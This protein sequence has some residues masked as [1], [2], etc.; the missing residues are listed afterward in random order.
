MSAITFRTGASWL[1]CGHIVVVECFFRK[2]QRE[3]SVWVEFPILKQSKLDCHSGQF[4]DCILL[5][6]S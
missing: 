6:N 5:W 2:K 3:R 1:S 4:M